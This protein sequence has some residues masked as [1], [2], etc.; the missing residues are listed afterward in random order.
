MSTALEAFNDSW[1]DIWFRWMTAM[2]WQVVILVTALLILGW[3][4]RRRS[5]KL[6]YMLWSLV[7][8]RLILPPTLALATGWA[9]WVLPAR[10]VPRTPA[11]IT[12][13]EN[14]SKPQRPVPPSE[15][16]PKYAGPLADIQTQSVVPSFTPP[17]QPP[18]ASV[19]T[20]KWPLRT[21]IFAGWL[22]G[23]GVM[24]ARLLIGQ[25]QVRQLI[26][27]STSIDDTALNQLL[28]ECR[29]RVGVRTSI[30]IHQSA[31]VETPLLVGVWQPVIIVPPEIQQNLTHA[32]LETV[33][34]HELQHVRRLDVLSSIL[35]AVLKALYFFHPGV[36]L[37]DRW[38]RRLREEACDEATVGLLEG[39]RRNYGSAILKLAEQTLRP[40]P[41]MAIGVVESGSHITHRMRRILDPKLPTGRTLSWSALALVLIAAATLLPAGPRQKVTMQ[42]PEEADAGVK[43]I[44]FRILPGTLPEDNT[45]VRWMPIHNPP[46]KSVNG[47]LHV[48]VKQ[49]RQV[50]GRWEAAAWDTPEH[51]LLASAPWHVVDCTVKE[52]ADRSMGWSIVITLDEKGAA[53]IEKLTS[54][55]RGQH[56]AFIVNGQIRFAPTINDIYRGQFELSG[57]DTKEQAQELA[58][59]IIQ[60]ASK[61]TTLAAA[62]KQTSAASTDSTTSPSP[63]TAAEP[64]ITVRGTVV[65]PDGKPAAGV[66]VA[67]TVWKGAPREV[68]T[69][70]TGHFEITAVQT[71]LLN[72]YI[73]AYH[74]DRQLQAVTLL[75]WNG[76][77][78][79]SAT[80]RLELTPARRV[81]VHVVDQNGKPVVGANCGITNEVAALDSMKSDDQG[82]AVLMSPSA[83]RVDYVYAYKAGIGF[84]YR[85]YV[86]PPQ[87][88]DD[89]EAI[90]PELPDTPQK[91]TLDG[92]RPLRVRVTGMDGNAISGVEVYP[93]LLMKP[94][95]NEQLNLNDMQDQFSVTSDSQGEVVFD[96]IPGW[97]KQG[98]ILWPMKEGYVRH[99]SVYDPETGGGAFTMTIEHLVPLRGKVTNRDGSLAPGIKIS[100]IGESHGPDVF[101]G[102][103]ITDAN[104]R[105][106]LKV[107]PNMIYMLIASGDKLA[108]T[109]QTGFA[110]W[111]GQPIE[112]LDFTMRP[113]TRLHGRLTQDP[114]SSPVKGAEIIVNHFGVDLQELD[115]VKLPNPDQDKGLVRPKFTHYITTDKD[116][117]YE[118]FV[119]N[120]KF[121]IRN[122]F[123]KHMKEPFEIKDE[124]ELELNFEAPRP[125]VSSIKGLGKATSPS[126]S[127]PISEEPQVTVRGTV[128]APDGKPAAGV[129]VAATMWK[130]APWETTTDQKGRFEIT[131]PWKYMRVNSIR[132]A[133][134][135]KQLQAAIFMPG[136]KEPS[137]VKNTELKIELTPAR[138]EEILVVDQ[139]GQ[140]VQGAI[141]G[142]AGI[143][144]PSDTIQ[145]DDQGRAVLM[146]PSTMPVTLAYAC[147]R[148]VGLDYRTF[149]ASPERMNDRNAK[150]PRLPDGPLTLT[151]D[152]VSPVR[153]RMQEVS[154]APIAGVLSFPWFLQKPDQPGDLNVGF[155]GNHFLG[156]SD[157]QGEVIFDW[158]PKWQ[159]KSLIFW[160]V[161]EDYFDQRGEYDPEKG[162]GTLNM[163]LNRLV[164]LRGKATHADGSPAAGIKI[165]ASGDGHQFDDFETETTTDANGQYELKVA[166][167]MIYLVIA[168]GDKLA[169]DP[170]TGFAVWPNQPV[171]KID[172]TMRPAT[173]LYGRVTQGPNKQPVKDFRI[174]SYQ[175]GLDS[176]GLKEIKLPNPKDSH[177]WVCPRVIHNATTDT[178]GYFELFVGAGKFDIRGPSQNA[179]VEFKIK[180]EQEREF[181]FEAPRPET[182]PL[183][184]IVKT[185]D[186]TPVA[187][188][189]VRNVYRHETQP[190]DFETVTNADGVFHVT[191][192]LHRTV[193]R[194]VSEDG[195][196]AGIVEIDED[197]PS[198]AI[199]IGPLASATG[200]LLDEAG[201]PFA[202]QE[203]HYGVEVHLGGPDAPSRSCF[204]GTTQT[205]SA[206][207]FVLKSLVV[208][209]KYDASLVIRNATNSSIDGYTR[210]AQ[211]TPTSPDP[212]DLGDVRKPTEWKPPTLTDQI[213]EA[214]DIKGTRG[215]PTER[216]ELAKRRA[217]LSYQRVMII[218]GTPKHEASK[219]FMQLRYED[220]DVST[221]LNPFRIVAINSEG[222]KL[223][224][225]QTL[226]QLFGVTLSEPDAACSIHVI[227]PDGTLIASADEQ[228]VSEEGRI[229]KRKLTT[230]LAAHT[231]APLN[232]EVVLRDALAQAKKENKRVFLQETATWC[233][234][235][236]LLSEYLDKHRTIWEKD[237]IWVKMDQRWEHC[238]TVMEP[239]RGQAQGGI[240]WIAI[241]DSDGKTLSTSNTAQG[242]N[243]GYPSDDTGRKHFRSMLEKTT[244]R[245]VTKDINLLMAGLDGE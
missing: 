112:N 4:L 181:N 119:G 219:Q 141:C 214:F 178:A 238:D 116:G 210:V 74:R 52:S 30:R 120:G 135:D 185:A 239:I 85:A 39:N 200:R 187:N 151:L 196:L 40:A 80:V 174:S 10:E 95:Q 77:G 234:P 140:P 225:A 134:P 208:G 108:S 207:Q 182:G 198:T 1:S 65:D 16:V 83:I 33:L 123:E 148:G 193:I 25:R 64:Q 55:H 175:Y 94:G 66:R 192:K 82:R 133:S 103:T 63:P 195:K 107:D 241:L 91:M 90:A 220:N 111:P 36:W 191:R 228:A 48:G 194:A 99:R 51:A 34:I 230:L 233:G 49:T 35:Q 17:M 213:N 86:L 15:M 227:E 203:I 22:V 232:A 211:V 19:S 87:R 146:L 221:A 84:D 184:G 31:E 143:L 237:F 139:N 242:E 96:W 7:P 67:A 240:P 169:A 131:A 106:E 93:W 156:T 121:D 71:R 115:N 46:A 179:I 44:E 223:A 42:S 138:R 101:R 27:R 231:L 127:K 224:A 153:V 9:W 245:L 202:G 147:K 11:V 3:V 68:T 217:A 2:S 38:L 204:G 168:S 236:W 32:E 37:A 160:P 126:N 14:N 79:E 215:T 136:W 21:W 216:F 142:M 122:P 164:P 23:V 100:A 124:S 150:I 177:T 171:D 243:I 189:K 183:E 180:Q 13:T 137:E 104:G 53:A 69:D 166:P 117:Y 97:Q 167:D 47:G 81:E 212:I 218:F 41:P 226:A 197:T 209:Q 20:A 109:P 190:S 165:M 75:P 6:R 76:T 98:L 129:R 229:S 28:A 170:Q 125:H 113:A 54:M 152:G 105:Y 92:V 72:G 8:V 12:H 188:A 62:E 61:P 186:N 70:S 222:E 130:G 45:L 18:L 26:H 157:A 199:T 56:L 114:D 205:D 29:Q 173:R 89:P 206:G 154:G 244:I 58:E 162:D 78:V 155:L 118:L 172:F 102:T 60:P 176:L 43:P 149:S 132:A 145:S 159:R 235:C 161:T 144:V 5:A 201:Q 50:Q 158:M 57:V 24:L 128:V 88:R 163:T 73:R 110:V 59:A